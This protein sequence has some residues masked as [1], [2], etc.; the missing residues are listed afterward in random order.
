[1]NLLKFVE[2]GFTMHSGGMSQ[3]KI[4]C[5]SLDRESCE[6]AALWLLPTL[7]RFGS[8][9]FVPSK[10]NLVPQWLAETFQSF[11]TEGSKVVLICDDVFTTGRSLEER[12]AGRLA[13]GAVIFARGVA[14]HWVHSL[15]H[16]D[17]SCRP[18]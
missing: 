3:F 2:A 11:S 6:T 13:T 18:L 7:G 12:R 17:A 14:P 8:V 1:M 5:D 15:L 4:E 10:S 9:E 16:L